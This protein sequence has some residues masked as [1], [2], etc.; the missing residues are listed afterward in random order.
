MHSNS[1][2]YYQHLVAMDELLCCAACRATAR[3]AAQTGKRAVGR[4]LGTRRCTAIMCIRQWLAH[5]QAHYR[6]CGVHWVPCCRS[7][8][9]PDARCVV[10][11]PSIHLATCACQPQCTL[12]AFMGGW[13]S[14]IQMEGWLAQHM[15][16]CAAELRSTWRTLPAGLRSTWRS[17]PA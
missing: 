16:A 11:Q 6:V 4:K 17:C 1:S 9:P 8:C 13:V 5:L 15:G 3:T 14:A 2:K 10:L 12:H 7:N